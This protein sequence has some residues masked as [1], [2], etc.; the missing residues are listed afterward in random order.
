MGG[1]WFRIPPPHPAS[2]ESRFF[3]VH[4]QAETHSD[5]FSADTESPAPTLKRPTREDGPSRPRRVS[6]NSLCRYTSSTP[7]YTFMVWRLIK[8]MGNFT[9]L[10]NR[11]HLIG[12]TKLQFI[13]S[14]YVSLACFGLYLGHLQACQHKNIHSKI[15]ITRRGPLDFLLYLPVHVRALTC[16]KTAE[17]CSTHVR[18]I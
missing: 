10:L 9:S 18:A 4:R 8:N 17:T 6:Q 1:I 14:G 3:S 12:L 11:P 16:P 5:S 13:H 15:K 7:P 2:A